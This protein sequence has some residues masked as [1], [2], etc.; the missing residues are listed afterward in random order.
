MRNS[1]VRTVILFCLL[2]LSSA[3][4]MAQATTVQPCLKVGTCAVFIWVNGVLVTDQ[5][6]NG[7]LTPGNVV[8]AN[9]VEDMR[10]K[11][12]AAHPMLDTTTTIFYPLYN[13]S[14]G[15]LKTFLLKGD[16]AQAIDQMAL[17]EVDKY[18]NDSSL[19]NTNPKAHI[20]FMAGALEFQEDQFK[21][22]PDLAT[23]DQAVLDLWAKGY[24][25]VLVG[26]SQGNFYANLEY[27][28]RL[29]DAD[30]KGKKLPDSNQL[31]VIAIATPANYVADGRQM[32][33]TECSDFIYLTP[34]M[35]GFKKALP[36]NV[37]DIGLSCFAKSVDDAVLSLFGAIG[38]AIKIGY[39]IAGHDLSRYMADGSATQKQIYRQMEA[40]LPVVPIGPPIPPLT[41]SC[42]ASPAF[43]YPGQ[44][45]LFSSSYS[46][47]TGTVTHSWGGAVS[48]GFPSVA[49]TAPTSAQAGTVTATFTVTDS[50][51]PK[52]T[53]T[54]TC[55]VQI[56]KPAPLQPTIGKI[57]VFAP[58]ANTNFDALGTGTNF[59]LGQT[60]VWVFGSNGCPAGC[61]HPDVGVT[62]VTSISLTMHNLQL[63]AG[64]YFFK[65]R[66]TDAGAWS[67]PSDSFT[68][69][70]PPP[71]LTF[72]PDT[73]TKSVV[74]GQLVSASATLQPK[75]NTAGNVTVNFYCSLACPAGF[76]YNSYTSGQI[77]IAANGSISV[78]ATLTPGPTTIPGTYSFEFWATMGN[79]IA[80]TKIAI[81]V[82]APPTG[83]VN[84]FGIKDGAVL[85]GGLSC[86]LTKPSGTQTISSVPTSLSNQTI[87]NYT[88]SSCVAPIG[89]TVTSISPTSFQNLLGGGTVSFTVTLTK[90][91]PTGGINLYV[92]GGNG[93]I[94]CTLN[95]VATVAPMNLTGK[96][97]GNYAL[98]CMAPSGFIIS[99]ISP[100]ATQN[101]AGGT[102]IS[103][104]VYLA[105]IP[106]PLVLSRLTTNIAPHAAKPFTVTLIGSG[107]VNGSQAY[108]CGPATTTCYPAA[109]TFN[110]EGQLTLSNV[111]WNLVGT[112]YF[113]VINNPGNLSSGFVTLSVSK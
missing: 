101:L 71:T 75:N 96:P 81:T 50:G 103:Y 31:S 57:A 58:I 107:F 9:T 88:L 82:T 86:I 51:N 85:N 46:F 2:V 52:Q 70:L 111:Q 108:A 11:F 29:R 53:V 41:A 12:F 80:K 18:L 13:H 15:K 7:V 8:W 32:Y 5:K 104:F 79:L 89:Y 39:G 56:N 28:I 94:G 27:G 74:A 45:T 6:I 64:S 26:H 61:R 4:A 106:K 68:V 98:V 23:L 42:S 22:D 43:L 24:R 16:S 3:Q 105:P 67:N 100:S 102:T 47:G 40:S 60:Q 37:N 14:A 87:G 90:L 77:A 44:A 33:T 92:I 78:Q 110:N 35:A 21:D 76:S 17:S 95:G 55:Q 99:S 59:V 25:V 63:G 10:K 109:T 112:V 97:A 34:S 73:Q 38:D 69:A 20:A 113:K 66:N 49:Y 91:P 48:G 1:F 54:A 84:I 36:W 30:G 93:N 72:T 62:N 19:L 83:T 65:F